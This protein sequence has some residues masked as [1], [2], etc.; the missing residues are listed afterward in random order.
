MAAVRFS[1]PE[2]LPPA[3]GYSHAVKATG[4]V[5]HVSGQLPLMADGSIAGPDATT[6][7]EQIFSNILVALTAA[8]ASWSD[9][10]KIGYYLVDLVDL[11]QVR[12][13]RDRHLDPAHLPASTLVQVAGLVHP[14]ARIEI[15]VVAVVDA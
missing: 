6:Q 15:E 12:A 4:S 8:G 1:R 14:E 13:V 7:T 9:V 3:N 11:P 2:G 10:V 5:I